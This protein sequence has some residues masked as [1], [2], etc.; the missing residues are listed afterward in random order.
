MDHIL[1]SN[2]SEEL[3]M[4][5]VFFSDVKMSRLTMTGGNTILFESKYTQ[6][7]PHDMRIHVYIVAS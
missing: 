7:L 3:F 1:P 2:S 5:S 4:F 6:I